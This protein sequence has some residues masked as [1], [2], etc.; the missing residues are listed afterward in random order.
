MTKIDISPKY[1]E[2]KPQGFYVYLHRRATDGSVF[3]VGK[4]KGRRGYSPIGRNKHWRYC[5]MKNGVTVEI[6]KDRMSETCAFTLEK[7]LISCYGIESL[8]NVSTGGDGSSGTVSS[9]R[10]QVYCSNGMVFDC[11]SD[12]AKW[13]I[14]VGYVKAT[15]KIVSAVASGK[16]KTTY[17]Y[18]FSYDG[19]PDVP[20][21][22]GKEAQRLSVSPNEKVVYCSNGKSYKN[23]S[24][25]SF[26]ITGD[27]TISSK[28][29]DCCTGGRLSSG[30][31]TWSYDS[32]SIPEYVSPMKR[33]NMAKL[34]RTKCSN[35]MVFNSRA[36]AVIW[37]NNKFGS[38]VTHSSISNAIRRGGRCMGFHWYSLDKP[39]ARRVEGM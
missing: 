29:R 38:N 36:E 30:G 10:K 13:L 39:R 15:S 28:I 12:A 34:S 25:A 18:A 7:V 37:V 8:S 16:K 26:S 2:V 22:T 14:T 11:G 35:G 19:V 21:F 4:G 1:S 9:K 20:S 6:Y 33:S 27:N 5:A 3:Y 17:G 32:D 31:L 23:A 24:Q